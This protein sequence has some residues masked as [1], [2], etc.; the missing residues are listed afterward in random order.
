MDGLISGGGLKP[1][2]TLTVGFYG[3]FSHE[4]PISDCSRELK[5]NS[6]GVLS[7]AKKHSQQICSRDKA[8]NTQTNSGR[9]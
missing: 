5:C 9:F 8:P 1:G 7:M 4:A 2:G 6:K 3:I